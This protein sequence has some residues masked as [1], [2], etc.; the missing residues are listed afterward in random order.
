LRAARRGRRQILLQ[1]TN[2]RQSGLAQQRHGGDILQGRELPV[3]AATAISLPMPPA[4]A[5]TI[6][7]L[8][9]SFISNLHPVVARTQPS[10]HRDPRGCRTQQRR[11]AVAPRGANLRRIAGA[12]R[13]LSAAN[14]GI[15]WRFAR[16]ATR[17]RC[18]RF[19]PTRPSG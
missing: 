6:A 7:H 14:A 3:L 9:F 2:E 17:R 11:F 15:R 19:S 10:Y 1:L 13:R 5:V 16:F 12:R 8:S 18:L 4:A